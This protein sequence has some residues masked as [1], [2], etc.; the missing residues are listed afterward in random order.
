MKKNMGILD[1]SARVLLAVVLAGLYYTGTVTGTFGIVLVVVAA[2]LV[3]T[4]FLGFCP[5]YLP[6]GFSTSDK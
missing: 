1:R 4:A 2:V 6:F 5:L 3:I